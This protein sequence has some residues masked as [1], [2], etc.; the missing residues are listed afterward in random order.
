MKPTPI[1]GDECGPA[2]FAAPWI[3]LMLLALRPE[4]ALAYNSPAGSIVIVLGLVV[5]IVAYRIMLA[6][7]APPRKSG[8]SGE[9]ARR[10]GHPLRAPAR[11]R[12]VVDR[13]CGSRLSRPR[14]ADRV[15]PYIVDVSETARSFIARRTVDPL[16]LFG[17]FFAP[18]AARL[19]RGIAGVLGGNETIQRRL[20]Q[21][22]STV[23]VDAF[24][25]RQLVWSALGFGAGLVLVA[26]AVPL[27]PVPLAGQM[28]LALRG[29]GQCV[30]AQG[31]APA[32]RGQRA[33]S[34]DRE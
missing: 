32:T 23:T 12:A 25:S 6:L 33:P 30:R 21:S 5:S 18:A 2:R 16:P 19:R 1:L 29:R 10:V 17:A 24:R 9:P 26:A 8:G 27:Q 14:L 31:L 22:G 7:G 3:V 13:E 11:G 4:A 34:A 20:R 15:A 28:A